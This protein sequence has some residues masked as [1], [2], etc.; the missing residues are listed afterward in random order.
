MGDIPDFSLY[1]YQIHREL[2]PYCL[3]RA[4]YVAIDIDS[5]ESVSILSYPF[6]DDHAIA[7]S[8][9][10]QIE[11]EIE[12]L[13]GL[14]H[15][16]I[17]KYLRAFFTESSYCVVQSYEDAETL[18]SLS[19]FPLEGIKQVAVQVLEILIYLQNF[20]PPIVHQNIRP[21]H[22]LI[23][24]NFNHI[25]LIG[26]EA[27]L[28]RDRSDP[29][30]LVAE[31]CSFFAPEQW[32]EQKLTAATDLYGFGVT[33]ICVLT[34]TQPTNVKTLYENVTLV[35]A[36]RVP[37]IDLG[38][39]EWLEK[40]VKP[41]SKYRYPHAKTALA[42]LEPLGLNRLPEVILSYEKLTFQATRTDET[43]V[44]VLTATNPI[45]E[46]L[47]EGS[48]SVI[49]H[50]S[51]LYPWITI[52]PSHFSSNSI[53]CSVTLQTNRLMA[54]CL[55]HRQIVLNSNANEATLIVPISL[56]MAPFVPSVPTLPYWAIAIYLFCCLTIPCIWGLS[57]TW[58]WLLFGIGL[59]SVIVNL[60]KKIDW[61]ITVSMVGSLLLGSWIFA[62]SWS[63]VVPR[64]WQVATTYSE[65]MEEI[66]HKIQDPYGRVWGILVGVVIWVGLLTGS[67]ATLM[68]RS[69]LKKGLPQSFVLQLLGT[70]SVLMFSL[71]IAEK[72]EAIISL[73]RLISIGSTI[74]LVFTLFIPIYRFRQQ[75]SAYRLRA[76]SLIKS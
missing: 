72:S 4:I 25:Y 43:L 23:D 16:G 57:K 69:C 55:F 54:N 64:F 17:P 50:P 51:D 42:E 14:Q 40:L 8:R 32:R 10:P 68:V 59:G 39:R 18:A 20:Y 53:N 31:R 56:K 36:D 38:L 74:G 60:A 5:Q 47:L 28:F 52:E 29:I 75:T 65:Y 6:P 1:G 76:R 63:W 73:V 2:E 44:Q 33:L 45:S 12:L 58:V 62:L 9:F 24:S 70:V 27:I 3:N 19:D 34:G 7:Q 26:F 67:A 30:Q 48:W 66:G 61:N 41:N 46:T 22:I 11:R 35:F 15:R 21:E 37:Q 13:Q 71:T 49:P